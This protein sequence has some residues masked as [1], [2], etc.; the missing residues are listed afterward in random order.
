MM[1][2]KELTVAPTVSVCSLAAVRQEI[3]EKFRDYSAKPTVSP[4][5]AGLAH[6]YP[7][8]LRSDKISREKS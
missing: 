3:R 6:T 7:T 8:G 5:L 1:E 4:L 2:K